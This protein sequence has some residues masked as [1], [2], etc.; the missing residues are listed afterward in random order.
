LPFPSF[1]HLAVSALDLGDRDAHSF[2]KGTAMEDRPRLLAPAPRISVHLVVTVGAVIN[3]NRLQSFLSFEQQN[4]RIVEDIASLR[5]ELHAQQSAERVIKDPAI[6]GTHTRDDRPRSGELFCLQA[7]R[8][9]GKRVDG[10]PKVVALKKTSVA[11]PSQWEGDLEDG[12]AIYIRYRH[13]H[14]SVGVGDDID[15]A[16]SNGKSDQTFFAAT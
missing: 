10:Q 5:R 4:H 8:I 16:V 13:G 12:R 2:A 11:C 9:M 15:E 14:L 7:L 3:P 1:D 6:V